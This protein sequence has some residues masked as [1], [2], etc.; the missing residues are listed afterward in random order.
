MTGPAAAAESFEPAEAGALSNRDLAPVPPTAR[1]WNLWHFAALWV[2]MSV[3]IPTYML[4]A[5]MVA[6][7][8]SWEASL[9]A[10]FLG[11]AVV[12]VP[13]LV[14]GHA[15]TKYGIPFPVYARASFGV[16]GAHVPA[17][18]R[19]AVACGWFGIQ[20]WIGGLAIHV[21]IGLAVPGWRDLGGDWSFMG[22]GLP[23]YLAFGLF[24][25][26]NMAFAWYGTESIKRLEALAAPL[27][28]VL[29][30]ALLAW[31]TNEAGG[32]SAVLA[33]A[34]RLGGPEGGSGGLALFVPWLTAMVG[35]WATL[36]LNIPDFTRYARS[37]KDQALGQTLGLLGTMPLFA[38][39]G[40]AVTSATVALYGE[41]IWNP[42][43][44]VDRIARERGA[45]I[46]VTAMAAVVLA[47]L[48]TNIAANVVAPANAF[49]NLSPARITFR[50][51]GL[52]AGAIGVAIL[53]WELLD[54]YQT[55]LIGYSGLL[56]AV[57]GVI[58]CDYALL[59]RGVLDVSAL[60]R[61]DGPHRGVRGSAIAALAI[62][63]AVALAGLVDPLPR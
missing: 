40:V 29:G 12:L 21:M 17:L 49:S 32:M 28:V 54:A 58:V 34:D 2:A 38:F 55:W 60:Y 13:M 7:G 63:V 53:P 20:T 42:I 31:A 56:G 22:H 33:G 52:I 47:T 27:L 48:S 44:L 24:W 15:G 62:G 36:A 25:L 43:D 23:Q 35:F 3:C 4:S 57:G 16:A 6:A 11:N 45:W 5:G 39:I 18:A 37:Q 8:M 41:A 61:A 26:V 50:A 46:G 51:G 59:R 1:T 14:N 10:V 19:A 30:L 9:L